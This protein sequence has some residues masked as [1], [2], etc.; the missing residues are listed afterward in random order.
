MK[1]IKVDKV[2]VEKLIQDILS[3]YGNKILTLVY[4]GGVYKFDVSDEG[5]I[6]YEESHSL[7]F[8]AK[9]ISAMH[10]GGGLIVRHFTKIM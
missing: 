9:L 10:S 8:K 6:G 7:L 4:E 1:V 3:L 5:V 2:M